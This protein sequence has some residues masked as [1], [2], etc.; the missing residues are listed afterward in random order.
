MSIFH[1]IGHSIVRLGAVCLTGKHASTLQTDNLV[2][3]SGAT[4]IRLIVVI[5]I[6][7]IYL[8]HPKKHS[9]LN[10]TKSPIDT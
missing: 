4:T 10:V 1:A 6:I 8:E 9:N 2:T 5:I 3:R 7:I